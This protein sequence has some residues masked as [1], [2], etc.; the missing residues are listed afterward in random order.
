MKQ[1]ILGSRYYFSRLSDIEKK[2]YRQIYDCWVTGDS[3]ARFAMPGTDFKLPTGMELHQL[4]T[5]IIDE[6]PHLFHL[7]TSQFRY[8]RRGVQISIEADNVYTPAEYR[9]VYDRLIRRTEQIVEKARQYPTDLEKLRFLH[10]YL[11]ENI[12][13]HTGAPDSRSQRE[14]H[15]IVGALLSS[16]CVCDGYARAFRLLCDQ[17]HLSCIVAIGDSTLPDHSGA[18]AWNFV[19][20]GGQV[21]HVDVTWDSNY[22]AAGSPVTD[23]YF[24]RSDKIFSRDHA[25]DPKL[26]PPIRKDFPRREPLARNKWELEAC[27]CDGL[28]AGKR[29]ILVR[30]S[31][32]FPGTDA[33][34]Q[35]L[36][37]IVSR[38]PAVFSG[39]RSYTS[40][41]L[42]NI[43]YAKLNF[44]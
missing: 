22:H 6:N 19:K 9:Q 38:N 14:V 43:K 4:V 29:E 27:V 3:V 26:Y 7:E 21:Y 5:Y 35:L 40:A 8:Q 30:L 33:L 34:Q 10:D 37:E 2:V 39:I 13:Y 24:M 23:Y 1:F 44:N 32:D 28:R 17:L 36:K 18:H 20:L 42:E 25:W 41:Y 12:L 31:D 15:T 11:A 16:A